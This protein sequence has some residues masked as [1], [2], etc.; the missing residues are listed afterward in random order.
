MIAKDLGLGERYIRLVTRS[1]SHRYKVYQITKKTGGSR[2]I[3]HPA[4]E[5]KLLQVW[6]VE[7]LLSKLPVHQSA[8]AYRLG[9]SVKRHA[10]VHRHNKF[11]MKVDMRDFFPSITGKDVVQVLK[12]RLGS[13]SSLLSSPLDY[14][15]VRKLTCRDDRLTIGAPSSPLISNAVMYDF[16]VEWAARC[17][18]SGVAY[19]RYADDLYFSTNRPNIL[20]P[21]LAD[22]RADL[23]QRKSPVL[24]INDQKTVFTSR[25]RR[26]LVTGVVITPQGDLSLGRKR[27]R[28]IR[29]LLFRLSQGKLSAEQQNYLRGFI[30]YAKSVEPSFIVSLERKYGAEVLK[31]GTTGTQNKNLPNN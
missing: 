14:E 4:K 13:R 10:N 5:L 29:S 31:G 6:L 20:A 24:Q 28:Y 1:A 8:A 25:K 2:T 27:K 30:S 17:V 26:K 9:C 22:L 15:T 11:L 7:K 16:D 21:L 18:Q 3:H 19:T 23:R 12:K